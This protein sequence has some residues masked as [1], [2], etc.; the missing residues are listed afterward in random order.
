MLFVRPSPELEILTSQCPS[1]SFN[2]EELSGDLNI[3][4]VTVVMMVLTHNQKQ[5]TVVGRLLLEIHSVVVVAIVVSYHKKI[6]NVITIEV[7]IVVHKKVGLR[8][9]GTS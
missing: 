6:F 2:N 5:G 8:Q 3:V 9:K 1:R 7:F 4:V